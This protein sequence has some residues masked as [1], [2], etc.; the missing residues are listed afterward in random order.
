MNIKHEPAGL[1]KPEIGLWNAQAETLAPGQRV[2]PTGSFVKMSFF[3]L[4]KEKKLR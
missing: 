2:F 1:A 3:L 4:G